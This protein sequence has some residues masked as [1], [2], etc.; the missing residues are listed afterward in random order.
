LAKSPNKGGFSTGAGAAGVDFY[1]K[2]KLEGKVLLH[3]KFPESSIIEIE[4]PREPYYLVFDGG[5]GHK[6]VKEGP[7]PPGGFTVNVEAASMGVERSD[8]S[9]IPIPLPILIIIVVGAVV[10]VLL[11]TTLAKKRKKA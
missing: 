4:I 10:L 9:G 5:P 8:A 7:A 1:V 2:N 11:I 6:I 3:Q